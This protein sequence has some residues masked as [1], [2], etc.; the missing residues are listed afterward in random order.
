MPALR[1]LSGDRT[2][3]SAALAPRAPRRLLALGA[4][5]ALAVAGCVRVAASGS[6][7]AARSAGATSA[8]PSARSAVLEREVFELVNQHRRAR[9]LL[10]LELDD[11][12][13]R[14]ARMHSAAMAAGSTPFGHD[15]Y[16]DRVAVLKRVLSCRRSAENVAFN[17]GDRSPASAAVRV[18][19]ASPGHRENIEGRYDTTGVG[20]A[21]NA[22]GEVYFT[23]I[24]VER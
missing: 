7:A 20:V 16:D 15:G 6:P 8:R 2:A 24:F 23:Q 3:S 14:E 10:A 17:Q 19:L 18:W 4:V 22:S 21:L 9:G 13:S 5:V 12:I 11:R 1:T